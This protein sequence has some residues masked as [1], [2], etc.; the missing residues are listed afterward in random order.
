M[1]FEI[2]IDDDHENGVRAT[3]HVRNQVLVSDRRTYEAA[4]ENIKEQ[5]LDALSK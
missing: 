1:K 3:A 4:L 5:I 2:V